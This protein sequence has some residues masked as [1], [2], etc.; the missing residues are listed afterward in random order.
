MSESGSLAYVTGGV[1]PQASMVARVGRPQW[2][3][4]EALRVAPGA[5]LAPRLS[6]DGKRVAFNTTT[7]DWDLWTCR[8]P[9]WNCLSSAHGRR[10]KR[11]SL[12]A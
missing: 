9:S 4:S 11:P 3:E 2:A 10:A 12:D 5:Y 8:R 7:G 1:F 6:P